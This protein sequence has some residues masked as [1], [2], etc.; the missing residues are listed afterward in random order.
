MTFLLMV[1]LSVPAWIEL[2]FLLFNA[3]GG[4]GIT[5]VA[6]I[7]KLDKLKVK[8]KNEHCSMFRLKN[9]YVPVNEVMFTG[10]MI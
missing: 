2:S 9:M 3:R 6:Y 4:S 1:W 7:Y 10:E 8:R 5:Y